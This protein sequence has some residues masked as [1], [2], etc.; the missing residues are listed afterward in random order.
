MSA[1]ALRVSGQ[2]ADTMEH[3]RPTAVASL[4]WVSPGAATDGVTPI[5]SVKKTD[6][7]LVIAVCKVI[8]LF[9]C[10]TSFVHCSF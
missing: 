1:E 6:D 5:F 8:D 4:G 9:S 10:T 7:L 3:I 2:V